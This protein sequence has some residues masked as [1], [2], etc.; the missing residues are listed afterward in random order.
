MLMAAQKIEY[1][2]SYLPSSIDNVQKVRSLKHL[3][4]CFAQV[5]HRNLAMRMGV[6]ES[7]DCAGEQMR[8]ALAL[9]LRQ[10]LIEA[11]RFLHGRL[12]ASSRC[13]SHQPSTRPLREHGFQRLLTRRAPAV[14]SRRVAAPPMPPWQ[15]RGAATPSGTIGV[16]GYS[17]KAI[18]L[19]DRFL[20]IPAQHHP[21]VLPVSVRSR[22]D[23]AGATNNSTSHLRGHRPEPA[24][25]V[26]KHAGPRQSCQSQLLLAVQS[27]ART[28]PAG[29]RWRQSAI[30][31]ARAPPASTRA[32]LRRLEK[33]VHYLLMVRPDIVRRAQGA[34]P[35]P[36]DSRRREAVEGECSTKAAE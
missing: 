14:R 25:D 30:G 32:G 12:C 35:L 13:R 36:T 3:T 29:V 23:H 1:Q 11:A 31:L 16:P 33:F 7:T 8:V 18:R 22:M 2:R 26:D 9:C 34:K 28:C 24:C 15:S 10:A 21:A 27:T 17:I 6:F 20:A 19:F 5:I 4:L